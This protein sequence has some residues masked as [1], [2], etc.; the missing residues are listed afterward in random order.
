M[1]QLA[2]M[3]DRRA[4]LF[5]GAPCIADFAA[6]HPLWFTRSRVPVLAGVFDATPAVAYWADRMAAIGHGVHLLGRSGDLAA[7]AR[8]CRS[9]GRWSIAEEQRAG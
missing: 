7:R 2:D 6:Y 4:F 3:L 5:G 9:R 1:D 8:S